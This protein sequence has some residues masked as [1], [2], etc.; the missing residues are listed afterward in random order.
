LVLFAWRCVPAA[1]REP[2]LWAAALIAVNPVAVVYHRKLWPPCMLPVF[3]LLFLVGWWH[4]DRRWGALGW[5]IVG[6]CLG[7]IHAT[8]FLFAL[9]V[10]VTTATR[11]GVRWGWWLAGSVVGTLP[12]TRWLYY[13][14]YERDP[15]GSNA[16][17]PHRWIE[18]KFWFH[19]ITE[20]L[21]LDLRGIF[22]EDHA[23]YLRWPVVDGWPTYAGAITQILVGVFGAA[24][25]GIAIQRW[26]MRRLAVER[27][28]APNSSALLV[29]AGFVCFGLFLTIAAVR[30]YRHY[31][32][33]TFPLMALWLTR[34]TLPDGGTDGEK[35]LG[36][37][38]LAGLCAVNALSCVL[39]LSHLHAEGGAPNGPFGRSYESL[40][41]ENDGRAP[42]IF[43]PE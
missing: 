4:R 12:M 41:R 22:G 13:L 20:P 42:N 5:G 37:R 21:G 15:M 33:V 30:F 23:N 38:L 32:I 39:M 29:R 18:G 36:R 8:G 31:L 26:W 25:L 19:W 16:L 1:E 24:I 43:I 28:A 35:A 27:P 40:V 17:E 34:L 7:Q 14:A 11:R 3:C 9:S 10:V 2:W 6:A